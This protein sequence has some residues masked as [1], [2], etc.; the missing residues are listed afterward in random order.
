MA[1]ENDLQDD[2]TI[3]DDDWLLRRINPHSGHMVKGKYDETKRR[4]STAAFRDS[5]DGSGMSSHLESVV[6]EESGTPIA[7]LTEYPDWYLVRL[8]AGRLRELGLSLVRLQG[9]PPD[10]V[11]VEG[12]KKKKITIDGRKKR[13]CDVLRDECEWVV[14]PPDL[15]D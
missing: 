8:R 15:E 1:D 6:I 4:L 3:Q 2:L 11:F 9:K 10:H 12:E 7:V 13:V 14:I 5:S